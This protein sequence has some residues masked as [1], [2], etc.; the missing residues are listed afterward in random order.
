MTPTS[1]FLSINNKEVVSLLDET[2]LWSAPFGQMLLDTID[3]KSGIKFL[4][5]GPGTGFPLL[6]LAQ[7]L[8]KSEAYGI[9]PWDEGR[10]RIESKLE[11]LQ[12]KNVKILKGEAEQLPFDNNFFDL[13]VS[14]NGLNNVADIDAVLKECYRVLKNNSQLVFTINLPGSMMEFYSVFKKILRKNNLSRLIPKVDE[15]IHSKRKSQTE[16]TELLRK[17]KFRKIKSTKDSFSFK[18]SNTDAMFNHFFMKIAF[19][20]SWEQ[21]VINE[22]GEKI[23]AEVKSEL[24]RSILKKKCIELT[25][26]MICFKCVKG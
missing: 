22:N 12:L 19:I 9:D 13:I 26:P 7:R 23:F 1:S 18:F 17:H 2:S 25:I 4:D 3:Y 15:H 16:W 6:E 24:D 10:R 20:P 21:I 5:I 14:N 11:V 8:N